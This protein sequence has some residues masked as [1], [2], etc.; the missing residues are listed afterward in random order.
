M[1]GEGEDGEWEVRLDAVVGGHVAK[2]VQAG[3]CQDGG[4]G[5]HPTG[6][7]SY[8]GHEEALQGHPHHHHVDEGGVGEAGVVAILSHVAGH[9]GIQVGMAEN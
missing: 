6:Q 1:E 8:E 9:V 5:T 7:T 4:P 3:P 2:A